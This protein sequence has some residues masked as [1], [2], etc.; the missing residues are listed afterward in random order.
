MVPSL[1]AIQRSPADYK[2]YQKLTTA[3]TLLAKT[4]TAKQKTDWLNKAFD[5]ATAAVD[6]YP[7]SAKLRISLASIAEDLNK[8]DTA[9]DQY[10]KAVEIED[11]FRQQFEMMYPDR[12]VINRL[13]KEKYDLAK[14]K[15]ESSPEK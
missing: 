12:K 2:N 4:A 7:G 8:T 9:L 1:A 13:S 10:K 5:S 11:S 3:Y 15:I 6:R 14:Q